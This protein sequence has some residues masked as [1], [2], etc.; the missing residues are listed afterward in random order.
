[1]A[2]GGSKKSDKF[3]R[4][5][6]IIV[7]NMGITALE[8]SRNISNRDNCQIPAR[9]D[10]Q[11]ITAVRWEYAVGPYFFDGHDTEEDT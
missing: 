9:F 10:P 11:N 7:M 1:M 3:E 8:E 5:G 2:G 6:N 4:F